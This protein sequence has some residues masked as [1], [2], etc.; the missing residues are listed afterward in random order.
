MF[1]SIGPYIADFVCEEQK[2]IIEVD[3]DYHDYIPE[4]DGLRQ[5]NLEPLGWTVIRYSN[6][7][8]I[9][10]L[11]SVFMDLAKRLGVNRDG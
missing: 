5:Q 10:S 4:A 2:V 7:D 11:E 8:V 3:G 1:H 6:D 9:S